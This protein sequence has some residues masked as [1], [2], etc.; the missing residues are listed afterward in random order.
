MNDVELTIWKPDDLEMIPLME[1]AKIATYPSENRSTEA[2]FLHK[3]SRSPFGPAVVAIALSGNTVVG[4]VAFGMYKVLLGKRSVPAALSYQTIV[5][6]E[7]QRRGLFSGLVRLATDEATK[8]EVKVFFNFPNSASK[9]GFIKLGWREAMRIRTWMKPNSFR[10]FAPLQAYTTLRARFRPDPPTPAVSLG[11]ELA[12]VSNA[13]P[14]WHAK[15]IVPLRTTA[16][17]RWRFAE[18]P[19]HCYQAVT[20]GE[21]V[22]IVRAGSRGGLREVQILDVVPHRIDCTM[23]EVRNIVKGVSAKV[24]A[25]I[26]SVAMSHTHPMSK[27]MACCG[28]IQRPNRISFCTFSPDQAVS[29]LLAEAHWSI[30]AADFHMS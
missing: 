24:N 8:R 7:F 20:V 19:S 21:A 3:Y 5:R 30:S 2:D 27:Y 4:M 26:I 15:R 16:F 6:P 25:D 12:G 23:R 18:R 9:S 1:D 13:S 11:E 28:M 10:A 14:Q 29:Q 22:V 17:L